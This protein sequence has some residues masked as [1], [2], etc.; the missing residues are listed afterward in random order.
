M[1]MT[2]VRHR[3]EADLRTYEN[4]DWYGTAFVIDS[5]NNPWGHNIVN[6]KLNKSTIIWDSVYASKIFVNGALV[7]PDH[8]IMIGSFS[9]M[10]GLS[11]LRIGWI[12]TNDDFLAM[13]LQNVALTSY[14][15]LSTASLEIANNIVSTIDLDG[16][17]KVA[18]INLDYSRDRFNRLKNIF[19]LDAPVSGMFYM[20]ILD[21][22]NK[23]ILQKANVEGLELMSVNNIEYIRLNMAD[24]GSKTELAIKQ[25]L[26]ADRI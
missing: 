3:I 16:F 23:K 21:K 12:G 17:E 10:L 4:K 8:D 14:C 18:K 2:D 5:P 22:T 6:E 9:K 11:G 13:K 24:Y 7:A 20:G 15:G 26:K 25:I 1:E 19:N